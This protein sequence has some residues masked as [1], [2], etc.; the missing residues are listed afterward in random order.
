MIVPAYI[1]RALH[2]WAAWRARRRLYA[3][4]P[5]LRVL[6]EQQ[7]SL[8]QQHRSAHAIERQKCRVVAER[9]ALECG[10]RG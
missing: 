5:E 7:A 3:A 1:R 8:A 4:V 2:S 10:R 6:D 9:L